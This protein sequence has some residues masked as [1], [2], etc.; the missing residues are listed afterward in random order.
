MKKK[1]FIIITCAKCEA[2]NRVK[3]YDADKLPVCAKCREALV[4][5]EKN[6]IYSRYGK[7]E[8]VFHNLPNVG[9]RGES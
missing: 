7:M 3:S 1:G 9:L 8:D 6:D 5:L 2:R 4:D